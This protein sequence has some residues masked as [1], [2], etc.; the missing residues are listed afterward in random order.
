MEE[1][2]R[3]IIDEIKKGNNPFKK[4]S[5]EWKFLNICEL[6]EKTGISK[7]VSEDLLS[8]YNLTDFRRGRSNGSTWNRTDAGLGRYFKVKNIKG[9][10]KKSKTFRTV[11]VQLDGYRKNFHNNN[12]NSEIVDKI[13]K[14]PCSVL[15]INSQIECDHKDGR[16]DDY[17]LAENQGE[18]DFQPLHK[19]V[20][21]AKRTHCKV[22]KDTGL[23]F[24]ATILGFPMPTL[25]SSREYKGS[26][27]PC[28][29][30]DT[31]EFIKEMTKKEEIKKDKKWI[32]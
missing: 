10:S 19:S 26:C 24:D 9:V 27:I 4:H 22:C 5:E 28:Y 30:N 21:D 16:K 18:N 13:C 15:A 7:V 23:M 31:K 11:G 17:G 2:R 6:D 8:E 25:T 20:N 14:Q 32:T 29:W 1:K 3:K 12:I